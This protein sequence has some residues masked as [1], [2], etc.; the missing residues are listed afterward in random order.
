MRPI[1]TDGKPINCKSQ[2]FSRQQFWLFPNEGF[3]T[4]YDVS[5]NEDKFGAP[6]LCDLLISVA[7]RPPGGKLMRFQCSLSH[8]TPYMKGTKI[9]TSF[10]YDIPVKVPPLPS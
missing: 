6:F 3:P 5:V 10:T 2:E 1:W 8:S 9:N 7:D 4:L